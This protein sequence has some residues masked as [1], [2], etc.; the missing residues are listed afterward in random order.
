MK[1]LLLLLSLIISLSASLANK[2][3]IVF[4]GEN[5]SYSMVGIHEYIIVSP[6]HINTSSHGFKTYQENMYAYV[7]I[8]E[9]DRDIDVY[10]NIKK[11][12]ILAEN[13]SW[14]SDVLDLKNAQYINFIFEK[15]IEPQRKRGFKN[16]FFDTLDSY[17]FYSKTAK[18]QKLSQEALV[19][20]IKEFKVR[21][22]DSKLIL[23]RGF[24][25][26]DA[27]HEDI[28]AVLF[29]SYY[30][31]VGGK[32]L[33][34]KK[35]SKEDRK[36][37]DVYLKKIMAYGIDVISVEYLSEKNLDKAESLIKK[38]EKKGMIPYV[39]N[40]ELTRY[41][42]SS[43]EAIKREIFT[44][45]DAS[46]LDIMEQGATINTGVV[47]EYMGY[48]QRFYDIN[49][50]LP[51]PKNMAHYGGVVIWLQN[52]Y[53]EPKKLMAW[54]LELKKMGVKVVFANN[55]GFDPSEELL[56]P[57][58]IKVSKKSKLK[59]RIVYSDA[60]MSYE[61]EPSMSLSS[62]GV[63]SKHTKTLLEYEFL[64]GSF[65][66]PAAITSWGGYALEEA[67]I[68]TI[69]KDNIWV[70]NPFEF[71]KEALDLQEL[72]VPDT[73]THNAKRIFFT[74][75]DGD[76][77]MN[78]V[79][80]D[81]GYYSG[82]VILNRILKV[83]KLPHSV[84]LIG[85]E[86]S[87]NGLYPKESKALLKIAKEMYALENVEPA[88]H[89]FTHPFFWGKIKNDNLDKAYR[90]KPKDYNFSLESELSGSLEYIQKELKPLRVPQTVF[91]SGDCMPRENALSYVYEHN[92]LNINGGDTTITQITP[93][94]SA[95]APMGLQ[96]GE[97]TQVFTGAQNENVFT[98]DWLGPYWGFKRVVQT[99]ELTGNPDRF[100]PIDIYYHIY[101]G[102]KQ[103]SITA[104][105]YVFDWAL[106]QD[107]TPLFTSEYIPKVMDYYS[108]SISH[109][110]NKWLFSGM[111]SLKT[112]RVEEVGVEVDLEGSFNL[113]GFKKEKKRTYINLDKGNRYI[114]KLSKSRQKNSYLVATN[115]YDVVYK[116]SHNIK[117]FHFD[118]HVN[119][120]VE[121]HIYNG[122]HLTSQPTFVKSKQE[123][124]F[125]FLKYEG[126]K[127]VDITLECPS[128]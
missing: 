85:A 1:H 61:I 43:K 34:Y 26:I 25:I 23:N 89:T 39:S 80:G 37:L 6:D 46:K 9:I 53:K 12:W 83:Y 3:A 64:D 75:V 28:E 119:L 55:F 102:S 103:A 113:L 16:F 125:L 73:T 91:W 36:W 8:G 66:T 5:I 57:L 72:V 58:G 4:Y 124:D 51:S 38:I 70:I 19:A 59:K 106:T 22:P 94:L 10:K 48:M 71:F 118:S 82:D 18:E 86:V 128:L 115:A 56:K 50:G 87:V 52:Y 24:S 117:S 127:S 95:I 101:S 42:L 100:K 32:N 45:I 54:V 31:G 40:K 30:R 67:F 116:K 47:F 109:Q 44:L 114:V 77:I 126:H 65:S 13:S 110:D 84:S 105:E 90:L 96:R 15:M 11:E 93:W 29:E 68:S 123:K 108:V 49:K 14:S 99:F 35:V 107:T 92:I 81:F 2:S 97:Y 60:M 98:N 33:H 112:L 17:M 21:Y 74:H 69:G 62:L 63:I 78:R 76:G 104:L 27:V 7:S 120:E 88:T 121:L 41:G 111:D 79:E 122:C 20:F